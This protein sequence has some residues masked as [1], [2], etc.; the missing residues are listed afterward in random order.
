VEKIAALANDG[1]QIVYFTMDD[2]IRELFAAAGKDFG[3][4]YKYLELKEE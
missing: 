1:W 3:E 4:N 2:N